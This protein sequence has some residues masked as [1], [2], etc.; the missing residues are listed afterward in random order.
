MRIL[1]FAPIILFVFLSI[2]FPKFIY[3]SALGFL[4][5]PVSMGL[6]MYFMN[7]EHNHDK[8]PNKKTRTNEEKP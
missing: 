8:N 4:I 5:C 7:K 6:M 3:L 1:C 2:F